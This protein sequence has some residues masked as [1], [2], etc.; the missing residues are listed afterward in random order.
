MQL[1]SLTSIAGKKGANSTPELNKQHERLE[2][3]AGVFP[4]KVDMQTSNPC[5]Q[6]PCIVLQLGNPRAN[7][8]LD[9]D[10]GETHKLPVSVQHLRGYAYTAQLQTQGFNPSV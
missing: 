4:E 3:H 2:I 6:W 9:C 1:S 5:I 10:A 7:P 8:W